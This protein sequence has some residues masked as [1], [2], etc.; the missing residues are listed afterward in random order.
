MR[1]LNILNLYVTIAKQTV[2]ND[3]IFSK[4]CDFLSSLMKKSFAVPR[5]LELW[6]QGGSS[7]RLQLV[8]ALTIR[9]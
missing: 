7:R 3:G 1:P 4:D 6:R 8:S 2:P 9:C 5:G